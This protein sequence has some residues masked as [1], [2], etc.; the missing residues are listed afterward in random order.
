[1]KFLNQ[2]TEITMKIAKGMIAIFAIKLTLILAVFTFNAC[3]SE[4]VEVSDNNSAEF[5][6]ALDLSMSN[7]NSIGV[8]NTNGAILRTNGDAKTLHLVNDNGQ[9]FSNTDFLNS[10]TDLQSLV[11][12][13]NDRNLTL[14]DQNPIDINDILATYTIDE[15]PIIDALQPAIQEAR[16][17]LYGKGFTDQEI[18]NDILSEWNGSEEHLVPFVMYLQSYENSSEYVASNTVNYS[19]IFFNTTYAQVVQQPNTIAE[20][21]PDEIWGCVKSSVTA[22]VGSLI[23]IGTLQGLRKVGIKVLAKAFSK[24]LAKFAGPIGVAIMVADF[25]FCLYGESND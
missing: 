7:L 20:L 18:N 25:G 15:Q 3:S 12:V 21:T 11:T 17:Y 9:T 10:V 6:N 24:L 14:V 4:D 8:F 16:N 5:Q 19:N 1:M 23:T 13:R 22:G 2:I